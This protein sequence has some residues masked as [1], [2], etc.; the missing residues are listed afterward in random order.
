MDPKMNVMRLKKLEVGD[1]KTTLLDGGAT[2]C[3]RP[4]RSREEWDTSMECQVALASGKVWMRMNKRTGTL[5]TLDRTVQRII[6]IRELLR[7]GMKVT[8]EENMINQDYQNR[9]LTNFQ[10]E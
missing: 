3:L 5:L 8:W 6:P 2:H 4:T 10:G 7:L 9:R 1:V